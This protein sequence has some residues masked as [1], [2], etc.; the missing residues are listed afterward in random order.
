TGALVEEVGK[1]TK[2]LEKLTVEIEKKE[3]LLHQ[4]MTT[5][6][7][8]FLGEALTAGIF[9]VLLLSPLGPAAFLTLTIVFS[10]STVFMLTRRFGEV[11][12][13]AQKAFLEKQGEELLSEKWKIEEKIITS[14]QEKEKNLIDERS[15]GL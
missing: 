8:L 11:V 1:L 7:L 6:A 2:K 3:H 5:R 9:L 10:I 12:I 14:N 15:R 4:K 13:L